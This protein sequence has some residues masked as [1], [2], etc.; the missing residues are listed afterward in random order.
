MKKFKNILLV[1]P[2]NNQIVNQAANLLTTHQSKL[3]LFSVAPQLEM[4]TIETNTGRSVDLQSLLEDDLQTELDEFA[5][6]LQEA[7]LRVQ[8]KTVGGE[9]ASLE[10]IN[11]VI[12]KKHDLVMMLAD[13]TS[14]TREQLFGT[15]SMRLMRKCPCAVWVVKP[16]R[17]RQFRNVFA[18]VD[19]DP[20]NKTRD[21]LNAEILSRAQTIALEHAANFHVVHAWNTL[22][23]DATRGRRWMT[24]SEIRYYAEQ[25][26]DSHRKG[27]NQ[28]LAKH[29]DG[30]AIVHMIQGRTS[31]VIPEVIS[32]QQADLLVMGTVCRAGIPGFFIGNT[33]ESI[34]NQV[35]CAVLTVKPKGFVS[36]VTPKL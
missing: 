25:V 24:K 28:L 8:T 9:D 13:G 6:P 10:I 4:S 35:D 19:P 20:N 11:Q 30:N 1:T 23:G 29:T 17:R 36:P 27:L 31:S 5:A 2:A 32:N 3:T 34:L 21:Q 14:S 16:T 22:G 26:A 15:L 33:A 18:A 7:G 12:A